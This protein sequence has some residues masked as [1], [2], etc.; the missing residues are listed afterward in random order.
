MDQL[1]P[2]GATPS[3]A[4]PQNIVP[5]P[6][7]PPPGVQPKTNCG[8]AYCRVHALFGPVMIITVGALFLIAN[9]SNRYGFGDLWPFLLIVAGILKVAESFASRE[10]HAG[11]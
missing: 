6:A 1:T 7:A 2:S 11:S 4:T 3:G 8:C 10:G 9:Y 5:Q